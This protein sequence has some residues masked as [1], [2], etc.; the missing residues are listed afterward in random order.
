MG[1]KTAR[2]RD[3]TGS[4]SNEAIESCS[5]S[6][7]SPFLAPFERLRFFSPLRFFFL[8]GVAPLSFGR[9]LKFLSL[10]GAPHHSQLVA[11][12]RL[13]GR[14]FKLRGPSPGRNLILGNFFDSRI[15]F[16]HPI[17]SLEARKNS[18][19]V[20]VTGLHV[21]FYNVRHFRDDSSIPCRLQHFHV[22]LSKSIFAGD[23]LVLWVAEEH[24]VVAFERRAGP[25]VCRP[26]P[27]RLDEVEVRDQHFVVDGRAN[28]L[29]SEEVHRVQIRNVG[30]VP[31]GPGAIVAAFIDKHNKDD[32]VNAMDLL[33]K[34]HRLGPV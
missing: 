9:D 14:S 25:Y 16:A 21:R 2:R 11:V 5:A 1:S 33:K 31:I 29:R 4:L 15:H 32:H 7:A 3:M 10:C 19:K 34:N 12:T 27:P 6:L 30:P 23:L 20:V 26:E 13:I 8:G 22:P 24:I 18:R 17:I 28:F